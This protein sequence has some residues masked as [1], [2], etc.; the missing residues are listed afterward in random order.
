MSEAAISFK[1]SEVVTPSDVTSFPGG[2]AR[3]L[4]V[5]SAGG[6][7]SVVMYGDGATVLFTAVPIGILP[8]E[9]TRVNSTNTTST[10]IIAVR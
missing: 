1:W 9:C 10:N 8:V 2:P 6:N 5:G 4:Y 7:I 3:G